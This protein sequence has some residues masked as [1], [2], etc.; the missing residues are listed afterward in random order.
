MVMLDD[1]RLGQVCFVLMLDFDFF[2]F[3][4]FSKNLNFCA[5]KMYHGPNNMC[6]KFGPWEPFGSVK[7]QLKN[8]AKISSI[9]FHAIYW[10]N[11][12]FLSF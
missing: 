3:W 11:N 1:V 12:E 8:I 4:A 2:Q 9:F 5:K 7:N 6:A 10:V